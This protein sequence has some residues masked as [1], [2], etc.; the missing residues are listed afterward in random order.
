[1]AIYTGFMVYAMI[2]MLVF[3][4]MLPIGIQIDPSPQLGHATGAPLS[5]KLR[6]KLIITTL[7]SFPLFFFIKWIV[8][9]KILSFL[10]T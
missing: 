10:I 2:W 9:S 7:L 3:F 4:V 6:Q 8:D 1:M 5:P